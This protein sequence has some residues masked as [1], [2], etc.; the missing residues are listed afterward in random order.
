[1]VSFS[2]LALLSLVHVASVSAAN[3]FA[4]ITVSNIQSTDPTCRTQQQQGIMVQFRI[5]AFDCDALDRAATAA[6]SAGL[7]VLAGIWFQVKSPLANGLSCTYTPTLIQGSVANA[8]ASIRNDVEAFRNAAGKFGPGRF[9]GLTIGNE[10]FDNPSAIMDKVNEMRNYLRSAGINTPVST[11]HDWVQIRANPVLCNGDFRS[12]KDH[13]NTPADPVSAFYDGNVAASQMGD[14]VF[15][16][17]IPELKAACPGKTIIITEAGWPSR[18]AANRQAVASVDAAKSALL[19]LNCA[20]KDNRGVSVYAFEAEDL[21]WK[22]DDR[23]RS[24]GILPNKY[25]LLGEV[26]APC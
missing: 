18:G 8:A 10:N 6:A 24:F 2:L 3:N 21:F 17:V 23:E 1:M 5:L 16:T 4:G 11:V 19:T 22:A 13:C 26:F 15:K 14:F 9:R 20:C 7:T 12:N 25:N